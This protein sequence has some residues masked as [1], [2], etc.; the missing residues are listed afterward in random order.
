[1]TMCGH[2]EST[3]LDT[4][5][6][7]WYNVGVVDHTQPHS[8]INMNI[9]LISTTFSY[10]RITGELTWKKHPTQPHLA[11]RKVGTS[12][13]RLR[14]CSR[15]YSVARIIWSL[16]EQREPTTPYVIFKDG[17]YRNTKWENILASHRSVTPENAAIAD[18]AAS[19]KSNRFSG[20]DPEILLREGITNAISG[21]N[22]LDM[23]MS[24]ILQEVRDLFEQEMK[25]AEI[26]RG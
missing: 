19:N 1:M 7:V 9:N 21:F 5:V 25:H 26:E 3:G 18:A 24:E 16:V 17:D 15:Y 23:D 2:V 8:G 20:I 14:Y 12:R 13:G 4:P 22:G 11:G 6:L 10:D